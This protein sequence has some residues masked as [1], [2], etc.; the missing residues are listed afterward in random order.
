MSSSVIFFRAQSLIIKGAV[1]IL[2]VVTLNSSTLSGT[3]LH[4]LIPERYDKQPQPFF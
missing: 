3:N 1:I 2:T 4:I